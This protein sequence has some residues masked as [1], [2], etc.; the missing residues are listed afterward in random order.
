MSLQ[1]KMTKLLH[2]ETIKVW[3]QSWSNKTQI[4]VFMCGN[5]VCQAIP[6]MLI[7]TGKTSITISQVEVPGTFY[8]MSDSG[9]MDQELFSQ[10]FSFHILKYTVPGRPLLLLLNGHSSHPLYS[11]VGS[12]RCRKGHH[13]TPQLTVN[14]WIHL[15]LV[16]WSLIGCMPW[17]HVCQS[18]L[19]LHQFLV[20]FDERS[21]TEWVMTI[22]AGFRN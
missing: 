17:L 5:A 21:Q 15:S 4:S 22:C 14:S 13:R 19:H 16:L 18:W 6:P 8:G 12:N 7:F 10:Y 2:K 3:Q 11:E 9:W 20:S 1:H